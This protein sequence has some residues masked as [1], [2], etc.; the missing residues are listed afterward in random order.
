MLYIITIKKIIN[1]INIKDIHFLFIGDGSEK[2]MLRLL[3]E[4][5]KVKNIT[6]IDSVDRKFLPNYYELIDISLICLKSNKTFESVIPF[7]NF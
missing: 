7:K 1:N 2:N 5:K 3:A 4:E 6:F